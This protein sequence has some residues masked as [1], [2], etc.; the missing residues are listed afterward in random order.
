MA[1]I[2]VTGGAGFIGAHTARALL[3]RGDDVVIMDDLNDRYDPRLKQARL[4]HMFQGGPAPR[5]VKGDI[6]ERELID[7]LCE[8]ERFDTIVHL[9]AWAS[10]QT[11][12]N[13]PYVYTSVNVDGTLNVL[14]GACR[15]GVRNFVF[16]SSSSV[17]GGHTQIP[18]QE[19]QPTNRPMSPYAA[20]K[21][22]G[23]IY[24]ATWHHLYQLPI[25]CLRF[26]TVYGPWGRPEMAL[27]AFT[28]AILAGK[29]IKMRG[30]QTQ[31]DFTYI[32]DIVAGVLAA[33]DRPQGFEIFN[34]GRADGVPLPRFIAAIE[35][36]LDRKSLVDEVRLPPGDIPRTLADI[37]RAQAALEYRP[38]V[39]IEEGVKKFVR[40][41]VDWYL[42][43]GLARPAAAH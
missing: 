4:D 23:E 42:P 29:P 20:S 13:N 22:A 37:S 17:Y 30:A 9:A 25:T 3:A 14:E 21:V 19:D 24:C 38:K 11:S 7:R 2:L 34:L 8:A 43:S 32:D 33:V 12:I 26:F 36:A 6:R 27:F 10:V 15:S 5:V 39:S 16:A 1:K 40:W 31:R 35:A 18:F 41:Y 28:E